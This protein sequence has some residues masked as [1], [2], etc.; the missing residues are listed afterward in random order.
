MGISKAFQHRNR[1]QAVV[2]TYHLI[3]DKAPCEST[4][5][6]CS[7]SKDE[8]ERHINYLTSNYRIVPLTEIVDGIR[9]RNS[10]PEKY[11]AITFDDGFRN[12]YSIAYPI[13]RR[14]RIPV[15]VFVSTSLIGSNELFWF[16]KLERLILSCHV[17]QILILLDGVPREVNMGRKDQAISQIAA[18]LK[19]LPQCKIEKTLS[20]L[21][22]YLK[23][24][25]ADLYSPADEYLPMSWDEVKELAKDKNVTIGSHTCHHSIV[26]HLS[27]DKLHEEIFDSKKTLE[28]KLGMSI[29]HFSY[30]NGQPGDFN[31]KAKNM[32][33]HAGY[34][35]A[36]TTVE[37]FNCEK[38]DLFEL[39]RFGASLTLEELIPRISG[40]DAF[41]VSN[42]AMLLGLKEG[43]F[44]R[45]IF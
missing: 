24:S 35:S 43:S 27:E 31:Q 16:D 33:V 22:G 34:K 39:R 36:S 13:L 15:T 21:E 37:Q 6:I 18:W 17:K 29:E 42:F 20:Q 8:F 7:I 2:L 38:T 9:N 1:K 19:K 3:H 30:P 44:G 45:E 26:R 40:V 14:N 11:L 4:R 5:Q 12:F 23:I 32:L 41:L 10:F 28:D 25:R